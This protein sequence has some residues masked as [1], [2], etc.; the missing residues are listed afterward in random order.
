VNRGIVIVNVT[1]CKGG[2]GVEMGRYATGK[3]LADI[4]ITSGRDMT[5]EAAVTKLMFLL[6]QYDN[7]DDVRHEV[8]V[9]MR[10][11]MTME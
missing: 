3:N 10:G 6:G 9:S 4:G 1:Q 7:P 11:E 5:T 8:A 2:G